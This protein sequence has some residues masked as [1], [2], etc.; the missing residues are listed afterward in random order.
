MNGWVALA[1][2]VTALAIP[3]AV[4]AAI[5]G[6]VTG[7]E[8]TPYLPFVLISAVLLRW[9]QAALVA[10][11]AVTILGGFFQGP[12]AAFLNLD[13]F[14]SGSAIFLGASAMMIG[15]AVAL[16]RVME[17][18]QRLPDSHSGVIF[19]LEDDQVFASWHGQGPP[20][21]LGSKKRVAAMMEDFLAHADKDS[22]L[23]RRFW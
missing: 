8:F 18:N 1:C 15:F 19:S 6:V 7:C 21:R 14:L 3:T 2:G 5:S 12:N 11:A 10:L 17:A 13:C 9:W 4:R 23:P 22:K 20:I 16:R